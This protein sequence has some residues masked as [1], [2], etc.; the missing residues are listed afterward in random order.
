[1]R[2]AL[3]YIIMCKKSTVLGGF[4]TI[5]ATIT[6]RKQNGAITYI[7]NYPHSKAAPQLKNVVENPLTGNFSRKVK[8]KGI[9]TPKTGHWIPS[10]WKLSPQMLSNGIHI[11]FYMK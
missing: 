9:Y 10:I 2:F 7:I 3:L 5:I 4:Y 6:G 8:E 1:M 11:A